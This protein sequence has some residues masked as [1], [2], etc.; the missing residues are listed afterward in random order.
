[1]TDNFGNV[2]TDSNGNIMYTYSGKWDFENHRYEIPADYNYNPERPVLTL[3]AAWVPAFT[4]E[5]YSV[6]KNGN[7]TLIDTKSVDPT[8]NTTITVPAFNEITGGVDAND[9]PALKE[10]TYLVDGDIRAIYLDAECKERITDSTI[11]HIGSYNSKNAT[12][13]NT[14]M[15][16][17]CK[18]Q[19][20]IHFQISSIEQFIQNAVL[21]GVYT[22]DTDLDFTEYNWPAVFTTGSFKGQIIGNGHVIKNVTIEQT[23]TS[24]TYFGLF[25]QLSDGALISNVTFDNVTVNITEGCLKGEPKYGIVTGAAAN[26]A[27]ESTA[28]T[29]SKLVICNKKNSS[30]T[31][32]KPEYGVVCG[33]GSVSGIT[34]DKN[35]TVSFS[36]FGAPD[37]TETVEYAYQLDESG[38]F[39][40]TEKTS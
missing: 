2:I 40:L 15:K 10:Q 6:D 4:Y 39:T 24:T 20:G 25:A 31:I 9:F 12:V 36:T 1:M 11:T 5:F 37:S 13:E 34:F 23:D 28:L 26:S 19:D 32:L 27:F 18:L 38:R 3:Y 30:T 35:N 14:T 8:G 7:T 22:L 33:Y 29:N 21:N 16:I 17:Y